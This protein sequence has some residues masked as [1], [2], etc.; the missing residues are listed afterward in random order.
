MECLIAGARNVVCA[1]SYRDR[2]ISMK[3]IAL[4]ALSGNYPN[5]TYVVSRTWYSF[6]IFGFSCHAAL[7]MLLRKWTCFLLEC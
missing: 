1:D 4:S 7:M 3:E 2:R 6:K 5:G